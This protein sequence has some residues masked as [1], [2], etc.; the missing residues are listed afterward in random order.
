MKL[1]S[2][3]TVVVWVLLLLGSGTTLL[4][5]GQKQ[6]TPQARVSNNLTHA[7]YGTALDTQGHVYLPIVDQPVPTAT[8]ITTPTP[9]IS[10]PTPGQAK[11]VF[12]Q[13][14]AGAGMQIY[15]M[16]P[17]G[18]QQVQL[19]QSATANEQNL[20]PKLSPD[21]QRVAFHSDRN[22]NNDL[23]LINIDG[24]GLTQLTNSSA[25]ESNPTWSPSGQEI[26]FANEADIMVM[27]LSDRQPRLLAT[28]G[29]NRSMEWSPTDSRI[30]Y[31][32]EQNPP[33]TLA[34]LCVVDATGATPPRTIVSTPNRSEIGAAWSPNG[35]SIAYV[36]GSGFKGSIYTIDANGSGV[37]QMVLSSYVDG[38][39]V[40]WSPD[41]TKIAF[42]YAFNLS[43]IL[44]GATDIFTIN[45][46]GSESTRITHVS[47]G[48]QPGSVVRAYYPDWGL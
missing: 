26:A 10:T 23:Y 40:N 4:V 3:R 14:I 45:I 17:D 7:V 31:S 35:T 19:T 16:N 33:S 12:V 28:N 42:A 18:T 41:G 48:Y 29:V 1:G 2:Y 13:L 21:G 27:S 15:L 5:H 30:L 20:A 24:T 9:F 22:G 8:P 11:I 47:G 36:A 32:C 44:P 39:S 37:E 38:S 46:D 43:P 6:I 25:N 34:D